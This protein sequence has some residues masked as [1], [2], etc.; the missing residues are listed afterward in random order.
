MIVWMAEQAERSLAVQRRWLYLLVPGIGATV[1]AAL[2]IGAGAF[3]R[4]WLLLR[5]GV[6]LV[7]LELI[8]WAIARVLVVRAVRSVPPWMWAT[9]AIRLG[10][11]V[12]LCWLALVGLR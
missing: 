3:M 6:F 12:Y 10:A 7:G 11:G 9:N 2:F 8:L 5:V 4:S 1:A